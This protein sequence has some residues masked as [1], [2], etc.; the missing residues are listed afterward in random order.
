MAVVFAWPNELRDI[1]K[2]LA[3]TFVTPA[4]QCNLSCSF[5]AI[6]QRRE[7]QDPVLTP[8]D[9]A[10]FIDDVASSEAVAIVSIQGYEPLLTESWI[11]T[12][13]ILR[14]AQRRQLPSG[15]VTN[16]ILLRD[17]CDELVDLKPTGI[18][19]SID[20]ADEEIH[21]RI[22]GRTGALAR[23][24]DGIRALTRVMQTDRLT[25]N[26]VLQPGRRAFL[27]DMPMLLARLG[28]RYWVVSPVLKI[29]R[30]TPGGPVGSSRT[31]V[32][33]LLRLR[34]VAA[35]SGIQLML[36]DE[37]NQLDPA[38]VDL[39]GLLVRRFDRPEGLLR[40]TPS[41]ACSVGRDI[42]TRVGPQT[43]VWRPDGNVAPRDFV[44][45]LRPTSATPESLR[46]VA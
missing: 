17:R 46:E 13:T 25:V 38:M 16:G 15:L 10:Y 30:A 40:L 9:Y 22:R 23:T 39:A 12:E 42:L 44:R 34:E 28:I 3:L 7:T 1:S 35:C 2:G 27:D 31:I 45:A 20:S 8:T 6:R 26:S 21:D 19:V 32:E 24:L 11:Y 33:D 4:V 14:T 5:C 37:L 29:G 43:P 36:D 18:T 41:G